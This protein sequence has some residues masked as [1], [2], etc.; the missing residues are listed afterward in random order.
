MLV[1]RLAAATSEQFRRHV[2]RR[3]SAIGFDNNAQSGS[4]A[5]HK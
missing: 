4:T 2:A 3:V 5:A 1:H